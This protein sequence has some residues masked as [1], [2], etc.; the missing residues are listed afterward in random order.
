MNWFDFYS[1]EKERKTRQI[2]RIPMIPGVLCIS[3]SFHWRTPYQA[4]HKD[5]ITPFKTFIYK[6][7][8]ITFISLLTW[9]MSF[10]IFDHTIAYQ[11]QSVLTTLAH[12]NDIKIMLQNHKNIKIVY[13]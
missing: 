4:T 10:P 11:R 5:T 7:L 8:Q 1:F 12:K 13:V 6:Y 9:L 2:N 3:V